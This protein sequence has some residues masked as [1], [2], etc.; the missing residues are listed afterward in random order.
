M[1]T[2][3]IARSQERHRSLDGVLALVREAVDYI[4]GIES[5]VK[6]RQTVLIKPDQSVPAPAEAGCTTDPFMIGA[7]VRLARI[8]G[9]ARVLVG[10]SSEGYP[11]SIQCMQ[12]TGAAAIAEQEGAEI[13]DLGSDRVPCREINIPGGRVVQSIA[14][15]VALLESDVIIAAPK[16]KTHSFDMIAGAIQ[17]WAG[18]VN[19]SW[20]A[21]HDT[22]DM[23]GE[24]AD[25]MTVVRP[26]LCVTDAL[27]CGEGDGPR[28]NVPHW[29]GCIF[30]STDPVATDVTIAL[31]LG[32]DYSKLRFAEAGEE[33]GLGSR[34]P[35]V[36]LGTSVDRIA[37]E[38]WP[39]HPGFEHLPINVLVGAGV[40]R[41]GTIATAKRAL[42]TLLRRGIL[43][44]VLCAHRT[45]T[46]MIG[47]VAD[48]DFERHVA[49]GPYVVFDDAARSEFKN[50]PRVLFF[51][52]HPVL[53]DV[54]PELTAWLLAESDTKT[55]RR[56]AAPRLAT[57]P[58]IGALARPE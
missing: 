25:L 19:R 42:N 17:L 34:A 23:V 30:A 14:L 11:D 43:E 16:A 20:R 4:G 15:P 1:P 40:T 51:A 2:V 28:A 46:V 53:F 52:G 3:A 29:C 37:F 44:Q 8:A 55:R 58:T 24:F 56:S 26:D 5:F 7:L 48:P 32:R 6:P 45:P 22:I 47:D 18:M 54:M 33:R 57:T 36:W 12:A 9:A 39:G 10:E 31:T 49:E 41:S 13:I 38:A 21:H 50:D 27:I 35:I